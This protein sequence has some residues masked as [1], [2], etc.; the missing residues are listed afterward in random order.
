M[1]RSLV[2][3]VLLILLALPAWGQ[4]ILI[5][6]NT[7]T[8]KNLKYYPGDDVILSISG[9]K[10]KIFD[11]V[12]GIEDSL[13]TL[14]E[15]GEVEFSRIEAFYTANWLVRTVRGLT[16]IGGTAYLALDSFNRLINKEGPVFQEETLL[17]S[18]ALVGFSFALIPLSY[19]KMKLG[20]KWK[21]RMI[22]PGSL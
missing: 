4:G 8:L 10:G 15:A 16:F 18:G 5:L 22:D 6:E 7:S 9:E 20:D 2:I 1:A 19:R 11:S 3:P 21:L 14:A 12:I 17:I 13:I